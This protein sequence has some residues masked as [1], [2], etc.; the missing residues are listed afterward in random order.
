MFY[1]RVSQTFLQIASFKEIK[2]VMAPFN[3]KHLRPFFFFDF[4][5]QLQN[6]YCKFQTMT[7]WPPCGSFTAHGPVSGPFAARGP[8]NI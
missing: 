7:S 1:T 2:K 3:K 5:L 8:L 4:H 6:I